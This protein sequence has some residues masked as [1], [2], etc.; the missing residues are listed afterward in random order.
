MRIF[1][2]LS[3]VLLGLCEPAFAEIM[4]YPQL[5]GRPLSGTYT[6]TVG[7]QPVP[8][9]Q[10][11]GNSFAWFA[12]SGTV[13][14]TVT[15]SQSVSSHILSPTRNEVPNTVSG[16]DIIFTLTQPRKLVLRN[17]NSLSE[18]LFI[19]ADFLESKP[20]VLGAAGVF[21]VQSYGANSSGSA[22]S[23]IGIQAAID[24]AAAVPSGGV[25]YVPSGMYT[26]TSSIILRDNVNLYMAPGAMI[27]IASGT[28]TS[29][30][31]FPVSQVSNAQISGRGVI[32]GRGSEGEESYDHLVHTNQATTFKIQGI[33]LL[34]GRTTALRIAASTNTS[35]DNV[36][37][38]SGSPNLSDG[39]DLESNTKVT[40]SNNFVY[41]SDDNIAIGSG[42]NV[43]DHGVAAPTDGIQIS[44]NIFLHPRTGYCCYGHVVS[45]VPWRGTTSIKNIMF[46]NND[47]I[48][49]VD[50]FS[51][52]PFG[53]TNVETVIYSNSSMEET[54][55]RLFDFSAVDCSSW[56]PQNCGQPTG[57]LGH[58][59]NIR[60][61]NVTVGN[62][63]PM[64][65]ALQGFSPGSDVNGVTFNNLRIA[66]DLITDAATG[67]IDIG[68]YVSNVTFSE[69]IDQGL[70]PPPT[71]LRV[72]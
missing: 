48:S 22:D 29:R 11:N 25:A 41:S 35:V 59:H 45:I 71:G 19:F 24:A 67:N 32:D 43:L 34:D 52:Y 38:L 36:K 28:Y 54:T 8:V 62:R 46:G 72:N 15:V 13:E 66:G 37:I 65:A 7:G 51:I 10:Y 53:G 64:S 26:I 58:I 31:V 21:N 14:V 57:V 61:N 16:N 42:T 69:I 70:P 3:A 44:G 56:G 63:P 47:G 17:V 5:P 49:A 55:G 18:Q 39:I 1:W 40:V 33:M 60:V 27:Q 12:F 30:V 6:L 20:P 23:T 2:W 68:Q 4:V 50:V 9:Q